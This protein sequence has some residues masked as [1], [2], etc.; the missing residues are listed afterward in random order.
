VR[1]AR[2]LFHVGDTTSVKCEFISTNTDWLQSDESWL[3]NGID[4]LCSCVSITLQFLLIFVQDEYVIWNFNFM[5][6][7]K[8]FVRGLKQHGKNFFKIRRDL[9]GNKDTASLMCFCFCLHEV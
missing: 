5:N 4:V 2:K 9:L 6:V 8:K 7:Q 3:K 1:D